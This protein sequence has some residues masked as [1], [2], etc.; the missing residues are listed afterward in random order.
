M[1]NYQEGKIYTIRCRTDDTLIYVGSTIQS[2]AKRWGGHKAKSKCEGM[3]NR[4][5]YSAINGEWDN[6]YIE[7]HS[8][9]PCNSKAELL[10]REGEITREIGNL[11]KV[12][13]GRTNKQW[14]IDNKEYVKDKNK[15]YREDP[16]RR[17]YILQDKKDYYN[18][19]KTTEAYIKKAKEYRENNKKKLA[20]KTS[21]WYKNNKEKVKDYK[22][23]KKDK[24][25]EYMKAYCKEYYIKKKKEKEDIMLKEQQTLL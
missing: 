18:E 19:N 25:K 21:E 9:Y 10:H 16:E 5:I 8:L 3:I 15:K 13:I 20:E 4:K 24:I 12:V 17:E 7:L 14:H 6:W 2:L 1:V 11:N 22:K 23:N